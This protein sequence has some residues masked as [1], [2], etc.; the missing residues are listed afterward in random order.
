MANVAG[1][2]LVGGSS[3][4]MGRDKGTLPVGSTTLTTHLATLLDSLFEDV[5]IVG[6]SSHPVPPGRLVADPPGPPCALRG[7]VGALMAAR[8]ERVLIVA[9][10]LPLLTPDLLLALTAWPESDA[11]VPRD[12]HGAHPICAIYRRESVLPVAHKHL[13]AGGLSL[14]RLLE[15]VKTGYIEGPDLASVDPRAEAL[16]NVNTPE[17]WARIEAH[18]HDLNPR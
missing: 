14:H 8:A 6:A 1:A 4:R 7:L 12:D 3:S 17:E 15:A 9:T 16:T 10:D 2:L 13:E 11:V 5:L 18:V